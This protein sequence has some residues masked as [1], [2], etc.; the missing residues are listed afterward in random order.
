MPQLAIAWCA[1]NPD[2][3]SVITGASKVS[4]V[5]DNMKAVDVIRKLKPEVMDRIDAIV[6]PLSDLEAR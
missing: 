4:Q 6:A 1:K 3:S 2:V 5:K